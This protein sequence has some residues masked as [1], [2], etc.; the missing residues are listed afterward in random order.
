MHK[1]KTFGLSLAALAASGWIVTASAQAAPD[2]TPAATPPDTSAP[3]PAK[4]STH[5]KKMH[6][7]T[8]M[9][10]SKDAG[11]SAVEDLNAQS[12]DAAKSGKSFTPPTTTAKPPAASKATTKPTHH[13]HMAKKAAPAA[14]SSD[15]TPPADSTP[16]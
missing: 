10:A 16:K 7:G 6:H 15:A 3:A 4:T 2:A 5:T 12:L 11:D 14:A 1:I 9:H 8:S 13:H